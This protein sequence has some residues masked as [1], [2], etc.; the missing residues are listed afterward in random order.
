MAI[1]FCSHRGVLSQS[2]LPFSGP[3]IPVPSGFLFQD[4]SGP[5]LV[6]FDEEAMKIDIGPAE[7]Q[8]RLPVPLRETMEKIHGA[9]EGGLRW[10]LSSHQDIDYRLDFDQFCVQ[11]QS[12]RI[13]IDMLEGSQGQQFANIPLHAV[14]FSTTWNPQLTSGLRGIVHVDGRF[15][16]DVEITQRGSGSAVA[17]R[18]AIRNE[19]YVLVSALAGVQT[20][21]GRLRGEVFVENLTDKFF[22]VTGFPVPE[23]TGNFAG[24]PGLPRTYGVRVRLGF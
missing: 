23:Q 7:K 5:R 9:S 14:T 19:A 21:D 3:A 11:L 17:D 15:N 10:S 1:A 20:N 8:I 13:V 24:Y 22:F 4:E 6:G 18:A 12:D 16:S 2:L